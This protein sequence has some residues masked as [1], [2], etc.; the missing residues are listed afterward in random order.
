[1]LVAR[2]I[3]ITELPKYR[4]LLLSYPSILSWQLIQSETAHLQSLL[5]TVEKLREGKDNAYCLSV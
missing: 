1:M 4:T 5:D 3:S 2:I